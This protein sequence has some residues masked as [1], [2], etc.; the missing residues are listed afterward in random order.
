M[1][2]IMLS[3]ALMLWAA[4]AEAGPLFTPSFFTLT[5][6]ARF[7]DT[8]TDTFC[9]Q[10]TDADP[11]NDLQAVLQVFPELSGDWTDFI[12]YS[13][14]SLGLQTTAT[15]FLGLDAG[16]GL[17]VRLTA[18]GGDLPR[19]AVFTGFIPGRLLG[20]DIG[21]GVIFPL[22]LECCDGFVDG[23]EIRQA[24]FPSDPFLPS[25]GFSQVPLDLELLF[26]EQIELV[27]EPTSLVL[28]G[29]AAVAAV[30]KRRR[31]VRRGSP[32]A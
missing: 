11:S 5:F 32:R 18:S 15:N 1:H 24:F 31:A 4:H 14:G 30:L 19:P 20:V 10:C 22:V 7:N 3:V 2:R 27:P 23:V 12:A 13:A 28:F 26:P 29:S 17:N 16:F 9:W 25:P 21:D 8:M 6:E